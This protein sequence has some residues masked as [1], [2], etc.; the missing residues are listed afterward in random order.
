MGRM[1]THLQKPVFEIK[2]YPE[3]ELSYWAAF[4]SIQDNGDKPIV[5]RKEVT[6][7]QSIA[8]MRSVLS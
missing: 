3:S 1:A 6:V 4:F 2:G 7:E 8:D 5:E